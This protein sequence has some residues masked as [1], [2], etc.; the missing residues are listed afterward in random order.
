MMKPRK[1]TKNNPYSLDQTTLAVEMRSIFKRSSVFIGNT[2]AT[3]K[4]Q[5]QPVPPGSTIII[6]IL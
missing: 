3:Y 4:S 2:R 5:E 6:V 1:N